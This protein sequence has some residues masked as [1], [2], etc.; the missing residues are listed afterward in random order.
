MPIEIFK[1]SVDSVIRQIHEAPKA[2]G[3]E[4]IYLPG[5]IEWEKREAW[6]KNGIPL[7][8]ATFASLYQVGNE[9]GVET[10][11]LD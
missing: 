2:K 4:R 3:S 5:E 8:E 9:L 10:R 7:P 11:L 1:Q 6:L